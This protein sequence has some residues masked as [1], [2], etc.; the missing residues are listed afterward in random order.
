MFPPELEAA[1]FQT[2]AESTE[3][4]L[5]L[6]RRYVSMI[7]GKQIPIRRSMTIW[8]TALQCLYVNSRKKPYTLQL[9]T[10]RDI[11]ST[12]L[13]W[14]QLANEISKEW[15]C[16][17]MDLGKPVSW[18]SGRLVSSSLNHIP[19][20]PWSRDISAKVKVYAPS[21]QK[22]WGWIHYQ[23]YYVVGQTTMKSVLVCW[24]EAKGYSGQQWMRSMEQGVSEML[25]CFS[26]CDREGHKQ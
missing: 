17:W 10:L 5:H 7:K 2:T 16:R 6:N 21:L 20:H 26:S 13:V 4:Q 1:F 25:K 22:I 3:F 18:T 23:L 8:K 24:L 15:G 9:R 14:G 19:I 11:P 12:N